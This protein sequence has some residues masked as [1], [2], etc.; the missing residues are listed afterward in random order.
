MVPSDHGAKNNIVC[1]WVLQAML[2]NNGWVDAMA[3]AAVDRVDEA[4]IGYYHLLHS[5]QG[6]L[7]SR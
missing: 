7:L 5:R 6:N 3:L 4:A 1:A 2:F